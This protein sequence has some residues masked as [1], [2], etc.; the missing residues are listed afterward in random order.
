MKHIITYNQF[1]NEAKKEI[2]LTSN[3]IDKRENILIMDMMEKVSNIFLKM[4]LN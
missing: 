1:L 4:E 2:Q 3:I